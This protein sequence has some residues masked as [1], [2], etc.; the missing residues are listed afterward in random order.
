MLRPKNILVPTDF[1][2]YSDKA[3]KQALDIAKDY[4]SNIYLVHVISGHVIQT[5]EEYSIDIDIVHQVE[6]QISAKA[7]ENI[8]KEIEKYSNK[9]IGMEIVPVIRHG[10]PYEEILHEAEERNA[11]LI[12]I[13]SIGRTG[14]KKYFLGSVAINVLKGA[15]CPVLLTKEQAS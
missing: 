4:N 14:I 5:V 8:T 11:D 1:S 6:D 9:Y 12:V 13:A 3:L 15:V 10:V 7:Q 2:E